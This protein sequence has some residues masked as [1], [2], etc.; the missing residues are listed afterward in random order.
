[1]TNE[2]GNAIDITNDKQYRA[3]KI[4]YKEAV[5]EGK[6]M[7]VFENNKILVTYCKYLLEH[8]ENVRK[9]IKL[10]LFDSERMK[11]VQPK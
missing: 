5:N 6:E 9:S 11:W 8:I 2:E 1:M 10:R 4:A 3:L 7:F